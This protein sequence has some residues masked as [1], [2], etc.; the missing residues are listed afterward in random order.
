VRA[1]SAPICRVCIKSSSILYSQVGNIGDTWHLEE[2]AD[3]LLSTS[4]GGQRGGGCFAPQISGWNDSDGEPLALVFAQLAGV[5]ICPH[6]LLDRFPEQNCRIPRVG[7]GMADLCSRRPADH[8]T[9]WSASRRRSAATTIISRRLLSGSRTTEIVIAGV[10]CNSTASSATQF[11]SRLSAAKSDPYKV[12]ALVRILFAQP[13]SS[14]SWLI[15][16][17][18]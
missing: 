11:R 18:L 12:H 1:S 9:S 10:G 4:D 3:K 6:F 14:V 13:R 15:F 2:R 7:L 8:R 17:G 5:G 16:P